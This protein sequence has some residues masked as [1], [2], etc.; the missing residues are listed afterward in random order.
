MISEHEPR[1]KYSFSGHES[2][3]CRQL[4]LKKGFDYIK[5]GGSFHSESAVVDLGVGKNMVASIRYWLKAFNIVDSQDAIT[6]FGSFLLGDDGKDPFL[7]DSASLWLLHYQLVSK[8]MASIYFLIFNEFRKEK[9]QF[10]KDTFVNYIKRKAETEKGLGSNLKT[11]GDDFDVFRKLYLS[12]N[13]DAKSSIEDSFSGILTELGLLKS[14][15]QIREE[16][17]KKLKQD[18]FYIDNTE[19]LS[20]PAEVL[21]Y[22]ICFNPTY[23]ASIS[24]QSLENDINSPGNIFA[25]NRAGLVSKIEEAVEL[26]P[27]ITY[28]DQAGI[29]ELQFKKEIEPLEILKLY[30]EK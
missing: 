9:I 20:L 11:V 22:A 6:D 18:F 4:W 25:L 30:Y 23:G 12:S 14:M 27:F 3:Q 8:G 29:K 1:I 2:F 24:L 15:M 13:D 16:N 28:T 21:L 26:Y 7:E 19:R 5:A 10:T 17:G